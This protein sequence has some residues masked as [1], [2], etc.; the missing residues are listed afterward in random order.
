[1]SILE[2]IGKFRFLLSR[3]LIALSPL[4]RSTTYKRLKRLEESKHLKHK[5]ILYGVPSLYTLT[6]KGKMLI[7]LNKRDGKLRLD[8]IEHD[9]VVADVVIYSIQ[10]LKLNLSEITSEKELHS[11]KGFGSRQHFPDFTFEFEGKSYAIEIELSLK[12][13]ETLRKNA[14]LNFMNYDMQ[15]WVIR[16]R[17]SL[18]RNRL[19]ELITMYPNLDISYVEE[20]TPYDRS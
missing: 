20:L 11:Q 14:E 15:I 10:K 2:A 9:I 16:K 19:G 12:A 4:P 13:K 8:T 18:L 7:G 5:H 6:H 1:M 17:N 3:H